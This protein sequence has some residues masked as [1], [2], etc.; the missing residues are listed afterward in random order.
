MI[1]TVLGVIV[2]AV[3]I[4]YVGLYLCLFGGIVQVIDGIKA[5]WIAKDIAFGVIRIICT[6][7]VVSL[8]FYGF[9][10]SLFRKF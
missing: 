3:L 8:P 5:G 9:F 6:S 2:S 7:F 10:F 1:K 4:I